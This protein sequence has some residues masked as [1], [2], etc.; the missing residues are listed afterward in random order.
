MP[1]TQLQDHPAS[2][3]RPS[4]CA[5]HAQAVRHALGTSAPLRPLAAPLAADAHAPQHPCEFTRTRCQRTKCAAAEVTAAKKTA[6]VNIAPSCGVLNSSDL[7]DADDSVAAGAL[8]STP[9]RGTFKCVGRRNFPADPRRGREVPS[10]RSH[11]QVHRRGSA[12]CSAHEAHSQADAA[13]GATTG[14]WGCP[15]AADRVAQQPRAAPTRTTAFSSPQAAQRSR[16][17]AR[18]AAQHDCR[19]AQPRQ[20]AAAASARLAA[21]ARSQTRHAALL[22]SPHS[23]CGWNLTFRPTWDTYPPS[24][25][26]PCVTRRSSSTT[27][28]AQLENSQLEPCSSHP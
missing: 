21:V 5:R 8:G 15:L 28:L 25:L 9:L 22:C 27:A 1:G 11:A 4:H 18:S 20:Q 23:G 19:N 3:A 26:P 7:Y 14:A 12:L 13:A 2:P 10:H 17:R 6:M 16:P 24:T